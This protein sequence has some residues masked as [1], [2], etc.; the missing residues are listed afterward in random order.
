[1]AVQ[2]HSSAHTD[3]TDDR[4]AGALIKYGALGGLVAGIVF[5][6]FEM[7]M[8]ALLDGTSAFWNPLRMI[9]AIVLGKEALAPSYGLATAAITGLI[10]HMV[11]SMLFGLVF[12]LTLTVLPSLTRSA[13]VLLFTASLYGLLLWLVNFYVIAPVAGWDWFPDESN[14]LVQ[15]VAHTVFFGA[16]LGLV[17]E[18]GDASRFGKNSA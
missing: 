14:V 2:S 8:A 3:R 7:I 18:R 6:M 4:H 10:V 15:L 12:G 5:A 11:L 1:M 16:V 13:G 9:G 17:L